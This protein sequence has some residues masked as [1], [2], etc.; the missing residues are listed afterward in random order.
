VST[1]ILTI[2]KYTTEESYNSINILATLSDISFSCVRSTILSNELYMIDSGLFLNR[3]RD[4]VAQNLKQESL[5][6][7]DTMKEVYDNLYIEEIQGIL[8]NNHLSYCEYGYTEITSTPV[9]IL[10]FTKRISHLASSL[11]ANL[12]I[13][14][15][16]KDLI[17]INY[18]GHGKLI[19]YINETNYKLIEYTYTAIDDK[20]GILDNLTYG[21]LVLMSLSVVFLVIYPLYRLHI[22]RVHVWRQL[23]S[24][25][26]SILLSGGNKIRVRML[27][28][29]GSEQGNYE[30]VANKRSK[31][32][33][34]THNSQKIIY[35][36][37]GLLLLCIY[38]YLIVAESQEMNRNMKSLKNNILNTAWT[39]SKL[40]IAL[41][42]LHLFRN[43]AYKEVLAGLDHYSY[44]S[45]S[46]IEGKLDDIRYLHK[47]T[48]EVDS[49]SSPIWENLY[50][51]F[52]KY[53]Y[54]Y[55]SYTI[56]LLNS[57]SYHNQML[58][59]SDE[60]SLAELEQD[61][62][63][64]IT[65]T[66]DLLDIIDDEFNHRRTEYYQDFFTITIAMLSIMVLFVF[67][68]LFS[69]VN[70]FRS[71]LVKESTIFMIL[72]KIDFNYLLKAFSSMIKA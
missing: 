54:G 59:S 5:K 31:W 24:I 12:N 50:D 69:Q 11:S 13:T 38:L 8:N 10:E 49:I 55:N 1:A 27:D 51:S 44:D 53:S 62:L 32:E 16:S 64:Y 67:T 3:T 46:E 68:L 33:Y 45:Y 65:K 6:I 39:K 29:H 41:S 34:S 21:S 2:Y 18:N 19:S 28:L 42:C 14:S 22:F 63:S 35:G 9:H 15:S 25:P 20:F 36:M 37:I 72:P 7:Y 66:E 43:V 47:K 57:M 40:Q 56:D 48:L 71:Q 17:E 26:R 52:Q 61:I 60:T 30:E 23:F 58:H 70:R 4:S